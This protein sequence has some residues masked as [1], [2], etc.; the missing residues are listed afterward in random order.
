M[1]GGLQFD[2]ASPYKGVLNVGVMAY[3]E[4]QHDGFAST[5]AFTPPVQPYPNPSGTVRFN[6]TWD[7]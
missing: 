1:V 6:P 7:I 3:Q 2:F 5:F 4:W